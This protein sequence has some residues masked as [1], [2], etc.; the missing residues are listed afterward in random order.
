MISEKLSKQKQKRNSKRKDKSKYE[1]SR[2]SEFV[3]K[4]SSLQQMYKTSNQ[5]S[6]R[7]QV[8]AND[9]NYVT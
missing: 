1:I 3:A 6:N 7:G 4:S 2:N 5:Y 8:F 9:K